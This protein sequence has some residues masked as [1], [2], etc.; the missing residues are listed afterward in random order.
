MIKIKLFGEPKHHTYVTRVSSFFSF[1]NEF[2][3]GLCFINI[4]IYVLV[5]QLFR[6]LL[7]LNT[8]LKIVSDFLSKI[9]AKKQ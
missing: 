1:L 4:G 9:K 3:K 2:F 5:N 8:H 6:K 7:V